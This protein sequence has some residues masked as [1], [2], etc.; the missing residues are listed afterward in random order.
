MPRITTALFTGSII[1]TPKVDD[2][3]ISIYNQYT[4]AVP[5]RDELQAYLNE[6][7]I[8]CAIYYP[9]P[10]HVQ[11]CFENLG[12]KTGDLPITER[13]CK[14]VL[15]LPV[16]PELSNEQIEYVAETLLAFYA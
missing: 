8:G 12:L 14:E 1:K 16:Y 6:K 3:N 7:K 11:E 9:V 5:R 15:S 13:C 4:I 10:L 2:G